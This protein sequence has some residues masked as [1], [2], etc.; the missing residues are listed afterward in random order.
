MKAKHRVRVNKFGN[1]Y[2]LKNISVIK[3]VDVAI[4]KRVDRQAKGG[5]ARKK[6]TERKI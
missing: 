1:F 3:H 6:K 4:Q 2:V 5:K